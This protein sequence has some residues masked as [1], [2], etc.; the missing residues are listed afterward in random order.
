MVN[1]EKLS[2][3]RFTANNVLCWE[4]VAHS[5]WLL[6]SELPAGPYCIG[7]I[8]MPVRQHHCTYHHVM[9]NA[10]LQYLLTMKPWVHHVKTLTCPG[11]GI[12]DASSIQ[13]VPVCKMINLLALP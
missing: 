5:G 10:V 12:L 7:H 11:H 2:S 3:F 9:G 1:D 8:A 6:F 13:K 4:S